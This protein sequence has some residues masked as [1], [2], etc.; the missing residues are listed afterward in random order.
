MKTIYKFTI[1]AD[2]EMLEVSFAEGNGGGKD[3]WI[4]SSKDGEKMTTFYSRKAAVNWALE[5]LEVEGE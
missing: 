2:K 5:A 1:T 3:H 4:V